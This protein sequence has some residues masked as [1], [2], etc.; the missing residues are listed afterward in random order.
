MRAADA[1]YPLLGALLDRAHKR[2]GSRM[3]A[4]ADV[5]RTI[6]ETGS[7]VRKFMGRQRVRLDA[8]TYLKIK[9]EYERECARWEAEAELQKARFFALGRE[10]NAM[11]QAAIGLGAPPQAPDDCKAASEGMAKG[12]R[13]ARPR[14]SHSE[15]ASVV[16]EDRR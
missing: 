4:Y 12:R 5:A 10:D 9:H 8:D 1:T 11:A 13:S 2:S 3:N 7:W 15:M 6:G 14:A 16:A